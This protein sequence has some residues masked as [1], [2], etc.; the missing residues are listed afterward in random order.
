MTFVYHVHV[1]TIVYALA[2][3][4]FNVCAL[5]IILFNIGKVNGCS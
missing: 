2:I 1:Y 4:F 3:I 5:A